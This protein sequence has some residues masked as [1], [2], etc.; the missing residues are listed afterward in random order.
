MTYLVNITAR[1]EQD[2]ASLFEEIHAGDSEAALKWFRGLKKAVLTL[3]N[4]P[5][6]SS[7]TPENPQLRQLLYGH[8]PHVY[9]V[10][11][12]VLNSEKRVDVLHVRHGARR[13]LKA[14]DLGQDKPGSIDPI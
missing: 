11:Y 1:A 10:I 5:N 9:R 4:L 8:R 14:G 2:F 13:R 7:A 12:R 6:R 3:E